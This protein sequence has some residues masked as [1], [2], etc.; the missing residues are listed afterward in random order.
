MAEDWLNKIRESQA[1]FS[2]PE[3]EGLWAGIES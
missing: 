1:D 3:P 2:E